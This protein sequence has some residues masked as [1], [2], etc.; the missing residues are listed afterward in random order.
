VRFLSIQ[1]RKQVKVFTAAILRIP[2]YRVLGLLFMLLTLQACQH[3]SSDNDAPVLTKNHRNSAAGY[4]VQL[5]L[6]YLKQGNIPRAKRKLLTA[7]EQSPHSPEANAAMAYFLEKTGDVDTAKTYYQKALAA[8]PG[9]GTQLNN[10]GAF[11]CRQGDYTQAETY[12]LKAVNDMQYEHT[13]GAYENAG[14]CALAIPDETKAEYYFSKAL[15]QDPSS[16]Q[17]LYELVKLDMKQ[18]KNELAL[19]HL[20]KYPELTLQSQEILNLGIQVAHQL[21]K[22]DIEANYRH[23]LDISGVKSS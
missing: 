16:K 4:N 6:G 9:R 15:A 7:L 19:N 18:G 22:A 10:Y 23:S 1:N 8:A 3:D 17:S 13:A 14:L 11:L 21:G 20:Q 2:S 5:G 12:F